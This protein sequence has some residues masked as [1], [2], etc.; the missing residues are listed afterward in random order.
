[1]LPWGAAQP[2]Q[3]LGEEVF[4]F[5][6]FV[7][8]ESIQTKTKT[9][10]IFSSFR[11]DQS[12]KKKKHTTSP[13]SFQHLLD[14]YPAIFSFPRPA[15]LPRTLLLLFSL[16]LSLNLKEEKKERTVWF[17]GKN[18]NHSSV[19]KSRIVAHEPFFRKKNPFLFGGYSLS[20]GKKLQNEWELSLGWLTD[21]SQEKI[22]GYDVP[23]RAA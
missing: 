6:F 2:I 10:S 15:R 19:K 13:F 5:F 7:H 8:P 3:N 23:A 22:G 14:W 12:K 4:L 16:T 1:M 11:P 20:S 21:I 9:F 18:A 17:L